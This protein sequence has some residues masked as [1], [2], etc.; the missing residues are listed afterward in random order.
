[1]RETKNLKSCGNC[2][3]YPG[4]VKCGLCSRAYEDLW[5]TQPDSRLESTTETPHDGAAI[6]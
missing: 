6:G 2:R 3:W 1:M 5:E 4:Y